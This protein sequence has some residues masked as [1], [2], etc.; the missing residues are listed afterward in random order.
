[1]AKT[2]FLDMDGV[3]CQMIECALLQLG[4]DSVGANDGDYNID[5]W[6]L[7]GYT[8]W[9][10][11]NQKD[12]VLCNFIKNA[13]EE[14]WENLYKYVWADELVDF[15]SKFGDV[16]FLSAP[17]NN[18]ECYSGKLKWVRKNYPKMAK[19][20]ILTEHKHLLAREDR[21]L[22]D[23]KDD[24]IL[25]FFACGGIGL[26]FPRSWNGAFEFKGDPMG[27]IK[28]QSNYLKWL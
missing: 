4:V 19:R 10:Y 1:M 18:P 23:D 9:D 20:L 7:K 25:N 2:I 6:T 13:K 16:Y 11:N 26:I 12:K 8:G 28:R 22:I 14:F 3:L 21:I 24:N 5:N 15:C 17:S 27:Y